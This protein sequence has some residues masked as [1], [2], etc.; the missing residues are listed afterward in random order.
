[1]PQLQTIHDERFNM[2]DLEINLDTAGTIIDKATEFAVAYGFQILG[3]LVI[4]LIGLKLAS[5]AGAKTAQ[6][7]LNR[8]IDQTL[9]VFIGNVMR[10]L[11]LALLVIITLGNFGISIAPLI[12]LAGASA[13]GLTLAIQG[14]LSNYGAGLAIILTRP[15]IV[16]DTITVRRVSGVVEEITLAATV[17]IGEDREKI[18]IPN[19]EIVGQIIVNS[20]DQRVVET[21]IAVAADTQT[22]K[23]VASLRDMIAGQNNVCDEPQPQIGIH[24]FTYGG[25]VLGLRYWTPSQ[26]YFQT[27]YA[28]NIAALAALREAGCELLD[29]PIGADAA[30]LSADHENQLD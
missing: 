3:S 11:L 12:A 24:D 10:I 26:G 17:L 1:M 18:T 22:D 5:W 9:S 30:A 7:A 16:G 23:A 8:N 6:F 28:V 27:R 13:F 21:R 25:V 4:F 20:F 15:F 19:K 2:N 29:N 14:P